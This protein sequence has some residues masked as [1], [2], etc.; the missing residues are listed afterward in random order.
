VL[1]LGAVWPA[2]ASVAGFALDLLA[3]ATLA[4]VAPLD[5]AWWM[6]LSVPAVPACFST[7][8]C[9][10]CGPVLSSPRSTCGFSVDSWAKANPGS[11]NTMA[12]RSV[13]M[14]PT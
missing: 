8:V 5:G 12:G 9:E 1:L 4:I 14:T 6:A 13:F 2:A 10:A 11:S 3:R 7:N